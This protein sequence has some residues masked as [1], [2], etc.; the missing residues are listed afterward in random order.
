MGRHRTAGWGKESR[1]SFEPSHP[2]ERRQKASSSRASD[3]SPV[4]A[5]NIGLG[6]A[7]R[8]VYSPRAQKIF[9]QVKPHSLMC[10]N[11]M[12]G[13]C[14]HTRL[15]P[16]PYVNCLYVS[17]VIEAPSSVANL[18]PSPSG[19]WNYGSPHLFYGLRFHLASCAP[20]IYMEHIGGYRTWWVDTSRAR[21]LIINE[22]EPC[23]RASTLVV[24]ASKY[25]LIS[26]CSRTSCE[27][28]YGTCFKKTHQQR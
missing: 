26:F 24:R 28:I 14:L 17:V 2:G 21:F 10:P 11:P 20:Y 19:A 25:H 3:P 7:R 5:A 16:W 8:A 27:R 12:H 4:H 6:A 15:W 18:H 22:S 9:A 23:E 1:L 13:C